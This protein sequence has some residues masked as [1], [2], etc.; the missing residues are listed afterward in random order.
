[1]IRRPIFSKI[2]RTSPG[3]AFSKKCSPPGLA[4][5]EMVSRALIPGS[6]WDESRGL[7]F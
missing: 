3:V 4:I 6:T 5:P 7:L 1:V 2:V